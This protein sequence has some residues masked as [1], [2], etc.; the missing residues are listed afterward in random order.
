M[1]RQMSG[2]GVEATLG[3]TGP[4]T[5]GED[6]NQAAT[7]AAVV[8]E[9]QKKELA[10]EQADI[11]QIQEK[12]SSVIQRRR[13][14]LQLS[15]IV[16]AILFGVTLFEYIVVFGLEQTPITTRY[17]YSFLVRNRLRDYGNITQWTLMLGEQVLHVFSFY[18][19]LISF[20]YANESGDVKWFYD[21]RAHAAGFNVAT[22]IFRVVL[23]LGFNGYF[24]PTEL[25]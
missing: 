15:F 12:L 23:D 24:R 6:D 1:T 21:E 3:S 25:A 2:V 11:S 4:G 19:F 10:N 9:L 16:C 22:F 5:S 20:V 17:L 7:A 13:I 14:Y 8:E 18:L